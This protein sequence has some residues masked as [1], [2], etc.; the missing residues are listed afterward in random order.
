MDSI[1]RTIRIEGMVQGVFF[2]EW[3]VEQARAIG[4]SGW[5]RNRQDGSVEVYAVGE[6]AAIDRLIERLHE[7]SPASRVD[8]VEVREAEV[9]V[10]EGFTRQPTL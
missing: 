6:A 3:T 4:V 9:Q 1:A 10:C 5:V 7:G 8:R 2:R